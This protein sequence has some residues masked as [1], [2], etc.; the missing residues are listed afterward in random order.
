[1]SIVGLTFELGRAGRSFMAGK[2][3]PLLIESPQ[4]EL[5]INTEWYFQVVKIIAEF[6]YAIK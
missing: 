5:D 1:M 2:S 4:V 6:V 3:T